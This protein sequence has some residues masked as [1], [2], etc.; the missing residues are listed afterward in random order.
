[1]M[2][3]G[4]CGATFSTQMWTGMCLGLFSCG[5]SVERAGCPQGTREFSGVAPGHFLCAGGVLDCL[6][7]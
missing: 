7:F 6:F 1:M 3:P 5:N 4:E 2:V